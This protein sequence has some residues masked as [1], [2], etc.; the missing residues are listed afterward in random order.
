MSEVLLLMLLFMLKT[1]ASTGLWFFANPFIPLLAVYFMTR[2]SYTQTV[3][4]LCSV[5][6][7]NV[8]F[9]HHFLAI[10]LNYIVVIPLFFL[11]PDSFFKNGFFKAF[12]QGTMANLLF[13]TLRQFFVAAPFT[14]FTLAIVSTEVV[15]LLLLPVAWLLKWQD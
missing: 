10:L 3:F 6:L 1:S 4:M 7:L 2:R 12:F 14:Y 15:L 9:T 5:I 8:A 11:F 13:F